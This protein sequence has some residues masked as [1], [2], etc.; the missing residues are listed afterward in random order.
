MQTK[1]QLIAA[2][3]PKVADGDGGD[4]KLKENCEWEKLKRNENVGR[5]GQ[6]ARSVAKLKWKRNICK[7]VAA[8]FYFYDSHPQAPSNRTMEF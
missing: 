3:L 7:K 4:K 1:R 2:I 8:I 6:E 5:R